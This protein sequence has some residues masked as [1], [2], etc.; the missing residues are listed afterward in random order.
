MKERWSS[1]S[2][3]TLQERSAV[4]S[5]ATATVLGRVK[6]TGVSSDY[7]TTE[8]YTVPRHKTTRPQRSIQCRTTKLQDH[9]EVYSAAPQNYKTTEKYTVP[10]HKL[11][12][13]REVYSAAPQT[14]RPQ[15]SIQCRATNYKTTEKYTVPHHKLQDHRE[16]Y[17][18]APQNYK[19]TEKY[20][21][22]R[23]KLQDHREVYSAAPQNYKTT[24]KYTVPHHK[25]TRPQRSIQCRA[26][27]YK[28]TEKYTV[29]RHKLQDHREVYSA[30]P[31]TTRPQR[32]IQCRATKLQDHRE[33]YSAAPQNYK[34]TEKYTVPRHKLQDHRE[35]Y[36]AAPQTTR[37]QRSIQCR[38]TKLPH[39][40]SPNPSK[41]VSNLLASI[42][43]EKTLITITQRRDTDLSDHNIITLTTSV[44]TNMQP[45]IPSAAQ[46]APNFSRMNFHSESVCWESLRRDLGEVKWDSLM[47]DCDPEVKYDILTTKCLEISEKYVPLR[48]SSNKTPP[49]KGN[50][51]RDRKVLMRKRTKLRKKLKNTNNSEILTQTENKITI[52]EEKLKRSVK[53]E[54]DR[55]EIQAVA[56]IKTNPKYFYK[57]AANKSV[58]RASVGPLTDSD[59][60][61]IN[62]PKEIVEELLLQYKSVFSNP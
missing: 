7:K 49:Y 24:E 19:T 22:P 45:R 34:T 57:Y 39:H 31:Q 52:I 12:D 9:R 27:N 60:R 59:G 54:D 20:T 16:V 51:P 15:R 4:S 33:V 3:S 58:M 13:H 55:K 35:V 53:L 37:P 38:A 2:A 18:A 41:S 42:N 61:T 36:S 29:P 26:T 5:S 50:I 30:A 25:T 32:S 46:Q 1:G 11:Q 28:T 62:E 8:K 44:S 17:S 48:R 43:K 21:V 47:K 10:R 40:Q 23:H 6:H 56:C 14:T